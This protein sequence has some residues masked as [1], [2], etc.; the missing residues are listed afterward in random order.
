MKN[1]KTISVFLIIFSVSP[2]FSQSVYVPLNHPVYD[3]LERAETKGLLKKFLGGTKPFTRKECAEAILNIANRFDQLDN[4]DKE[5]VV[6]FISEFIE[7]FDEKNI[8]PVMNL[9]P[10]FKLPAKLG[11][12]P[13]IIY[14]PSEQRLMT[15]MNT[16]KFAYCKSGRCF[17]FRY[18]RYI[19]I[20]FHGDT[21]LSAEGFPLK[22]GE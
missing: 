14:K 20:D 4:L 15:Q 2:L 16:F 19:F 10:D 17:S 18:F 8:E 3:Y 1:I 6:F 22:R 7:E 11:M 21:Q 9:L 12:F 13:G 5:N